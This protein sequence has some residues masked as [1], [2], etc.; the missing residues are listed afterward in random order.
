MAKIYPLKGHFNVLSVLSFKWSCQ[1]EYFYMNK[2]TLKVLFCGKA[3]GIFI[4]RN[5]KFGF[6]YLERLSLRTVNTEWRQLSDFDF[7]RENRLLG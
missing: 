1:E 6:S 5:S 2:K 3:R 7:Q 4:D